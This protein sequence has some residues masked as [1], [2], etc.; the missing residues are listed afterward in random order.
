M[1][2]GLRNP[3]RMNRQGKLAGT[4][5]HP[6]NS[7]HSTKDTASGS[8]SHIGV[9][10]NMEPARFNARILVVEDAPVN[11][12]V[13]LEMLTHLGCVVDIAENGTEA[14]KAIHRTGYDIIL[15]DCQMPVMDGYEATRKIREME[16]SAAKNLPPGM[17]VPHIA[18][19]ALTAHA[20]TGDR[21]LCLDAGMDDYVTKPFSLRLM[22]EM[23]EHWAPSSQ[24]IGHLSNGGESQA[25]QGEEHLDADPGAIDTSCIDTIRGLQRPGRPDILAKTIA[26]YFEDAGGLVTAIREG[27]AAGEAVTVHRAA[28]RLKSSS[29]VLGAS[30]LA[31]YCRDLEELCRDGELPA[32]N[33]LVALIERGYRQARIGLEPY[34]VE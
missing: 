31:S 8:K 7:L 30:R 28:H 25:Y 4:A 33:S 29:A 34:Q 5:D 19:V 13:A 12:A 9:E 16:R 1:L 24:V 22:S 21:Q 14:L 23:L 2:S 26:C 32:D 3:F 10:P 18:I 6:M 27:F 11:Q 15:M 20:M 17:P